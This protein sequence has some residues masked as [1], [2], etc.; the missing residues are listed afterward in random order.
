MEIGE[1]RYKR[2]CVLLCALLVLM[3]A[4]CVTGCGKQA[5]YVQEAASQE[6]EQA[7]GAAESA[8]ILSSPEEI[9]LTDTDGNG[10]NYVFTYNGIEFQARY[11]PDNW[12]IIDSY[13]VTEQEDMKIIC[14]A[15]SEV[16]PIHGRDMVSYRTPED[17]AYEWQQHNIVFY[18]L[19]EESPQ[20][21]NVKD[22]DLDP[23]DQGKS[24]VEMYRDRKNGSS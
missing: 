18:L 1:K 17:M 9:G 12:K 11:T 16:H 23:K 2:S 6:T 8:A 14:E 7:A 13:R 10:K 3:A 5:E 20:R 24:Y 15:L 22:V 4:V 19:P 21:Q